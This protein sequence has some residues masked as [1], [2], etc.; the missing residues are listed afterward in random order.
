MI[1]AP[2]PTASSSSKD[3]SWRIRPMTDGD[4][5]VVLAIERASFSSP[6]SRAMF[7]AELHENAFARFFVAEQGVP[8]E[9]VGYVGGWL[10]LDELHIL[11]V[12]VRPDLR[13]R[14]IALALLDRLFQAGA[15][16]VMKASLEVRRSNAAARAIYER[17][18]FRRVGVRRGYYSEPQED[19]VLMQWTRT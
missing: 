10:I 16:P 15:V 14:G 3:V 8:A 18:G 9:I 17:I 11:S 7:G 12:A 13:Q 19:A 6:W 4:L 5:D 2:V 1:D